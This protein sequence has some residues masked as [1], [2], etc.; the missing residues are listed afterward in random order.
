MKCPWQNLCPSPSGSACVWPTAAGSILGVNCKAVWSITEKALIH[1]QS[2]L[3]HHIEMFS[4]TF[5]FFSQFMAR[6]LHDSIE[7]QNSANPRTVLQP[8]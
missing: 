4:P 6:V 8:V 5:P 3:G 2:F 7:K 1:H